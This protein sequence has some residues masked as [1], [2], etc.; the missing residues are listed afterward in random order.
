MSILERTFFPLAIFFTVLFGI[1]LGVRVTNSIM[2]SM[3]CADYIKRAT[4]ANTVEMAK[5]E[6]AKAI[7]YA[8]RKNLTEGIVS[9]FLKQPKN[10]IGFWY[11]NMK[12]GYEELDN[13]REDTTSLEKTNVLMK[14]RESLTDSNDKGTSVTV[15][16]GI[17]VYPYNVV[18]FIW[19][20]GTFLLMIVFWGVLLIDLLE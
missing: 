18:Y 8:E 11:E 13:L 16:D 17:T 19:G 4:S 1:W 20:F 9:I 6:L 12:A 14:L 2:F 10:D 15:P 5:R 7:D 3:N